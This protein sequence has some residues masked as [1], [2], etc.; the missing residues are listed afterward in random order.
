MSKNIPLGIPNY[1]PWYINTLPGQNKM[2]EMNK[3]HSFINNVLLSE[4]IKEFQGRKT[5]EFIN[6]G[7]NQLI[8]VVTINDNNRYTL[9]VNQ[10]ATNSKMGEAEYQNL[11]QFSK[12]NHN[13]IK[14]LYYFTDQQNPSLEL[15]ITPYE[16]QA[17][18]I[19]VEDKTWGM[20][21]PEPDYYF[22]EFSDK[23]KLIINSSMLA[24]LIKFYDEKKTSAIINCKLDGGDFMLKKRAQTNNM[25]YSTILSNLELI[26]LRNVMHISLNDY[27][28]LMRYELTTDSSNNLFLLRKLRAKISNEEVNLGIEK[29]LELRRI[30]K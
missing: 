17:R 29:G 6:Y 1:G 14:P 24:L 15:Y 22:Q 20:W 26:A 8:Y 23:Q 30:K 27:I 7:S 19:G 5:V 4:N 13:I 18:C 11:L 28:D 2:E 3:I 10:P 12:I 16:Y 21:I 25:N 9:V